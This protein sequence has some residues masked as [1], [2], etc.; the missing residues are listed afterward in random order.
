MNNELVYKLKIKRIEKSSDPDYINALKIYNETTPYE[1]KTN[2]NEITKWLDS[3]NPTV[4]FEPMFFALYFTENLVGFAMMTYIRTQRIVILEYISIIAQ[5]RVNTI[6]LSF[7]S[8][9]ES[10]LNVNQ[11][12]ISFFVNEISNRK[13]GKEID[14]ES[15]IFSKA[16]CIEGYG[17]INA[18]YCTPPLGLNNYESS[19]DAYLFIKTAGDIH[20]LEKQTYLDIV[21]SIYFEYFSNW[22]AFVLLPNELAEYNELLFKCFDYLSNKITEFTSIS[23]I[24]SE[25]PIL[26]NNSQTLK[27][28]GLP[29]LVKKKTKLLTYVVLGAILVLCPIAVVWLYNYIL[30]ILGFSMGIAG[31]IIGNC[32]GSILTACVT[33]YIAKKH[34]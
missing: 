20:S 10:Y 30:S 25:C 33:L 24:Y 11:Y 19:F 21:K 34:L 13:D 27:T 29:L 32:V 17:K 23:V 5:Y 9:L 4:P 12:D 6:F 18:P 31:E 16:L 3:K 7:I 1:I 15:Q 8:L 28:S 22:Y 26:K 2:T 14:K